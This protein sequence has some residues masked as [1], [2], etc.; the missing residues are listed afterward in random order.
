MGIYIID[1]QNIKL[2]DDAGLHAWSCWKQ[3]YYIDSWYKNKHKM[4]LKTNN[5]F[6]S[7]PL[8]IVG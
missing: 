6:R 5:P 8:T 2:V 7:M 4:L 3:W 1:L